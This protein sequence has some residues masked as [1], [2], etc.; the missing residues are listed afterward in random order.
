MGGSYG[1]TAHY[2]VMAES[3]RVYVREAGVVSK[4]DLE[5][6][7]HFSEGDC[8]GWRNLDVG[9]IAY[10]W[11]RDGSESLVRY[12]IT[13]DTIDVGAEIEF[14]DSYKNMR[15]HVYTVDWFAA[16]APTPEPTKRRVISHG[17]IGHP[18]EGIPNAHETTVRYQWVDEGTCFPTAGAIK[19]IKFFVG[20]TGYFWLTI[21]R[22][23]G[24][25][26]A[27]GK[28]YW[29]I[30]KKSEMIY[31]RNLNE[32]NTW[33]FETQMDF[34]EG[35]CVGWEDNGMTVLGLTDHTAAKAADS[36]TNVWRYYP[37]DYAFVEEGGTIGF[38]RGYSQ[39]KSYAYTIIY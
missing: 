9:V 31:G 15:S 13:L 24:E 10:G 23:V 25:D 22:F 39:R 26:T 34:N 18:V 2:R 6:P 4:I 30:I 36:Y 33:D 19:S 35:D 20:Y 1:R 11:P 27:K 14:I 5:T 37:G 32:V 16:P 17:E 7:L 8:F 38:N 21:N 3:E 29:K 28:F 12:R